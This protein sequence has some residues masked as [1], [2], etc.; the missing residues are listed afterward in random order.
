[1]HRAFIVYCLA[2]LNFFDAHLMKKLKINGITEV[3]GATSKS[4][5]L[6]PPTTDTQS[7]RAAQFLG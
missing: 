1:M 7:V 5:G 4:V 6:G 3:E 2:L